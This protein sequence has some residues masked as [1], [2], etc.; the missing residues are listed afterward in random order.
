MNRI[1]SSVSTYNKHYKPAHIHNVHILA[2]W[3]VVILGTN[4]FFHSTQSIQLI[5]HSLDLS[6][7]VCNPIYGADIVKRGNY[8][9]QDHMRPHFKTAEHS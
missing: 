6:R 5:Q 3:T 9:V 7:M 2:P 1:L 8:L 4:N